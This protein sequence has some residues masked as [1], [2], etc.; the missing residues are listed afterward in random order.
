MIFIEGGNHN[1]T[2]LN[3]MDHLSPS[4]LKIIVKVVVVVDN[5]T[6]TTSWMTSSLSTQ[7]CVF[8]TGCLME[9]WMNW[10][11]LLD[12]S[13]SLLYA[14]TSLSA[15]TSTM[16][17]I[18]SVGTSLAYHKDRRLMRRIKEFKITSAQESILGHEDI[19]IF[20]G[21]NQIQTIKAEYSG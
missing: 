14:A 8:M 11:W 10:R 21:L 4:N 2:K 15:S 17:V 7:G 16:I 13:F 3:K 1:S 6:S 18:S 9:S 12:T 19:R 5:L 20:K